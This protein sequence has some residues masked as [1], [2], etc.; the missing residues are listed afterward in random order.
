[1]HLVCNQKLLAQ[2]I[3]ICQKAISNKTTNDILKG[4]LLVAKDNALTL[5]GYDLEIAIETSLE[6][7]IYEEGS[8]VLDSRLFGDI[9]KK[10][11]DTFIEIK[12][13]Q[14]SVCV[15][16]ENSKFEIKSDNS[17]DFPRVPI[18]DSSKKCYISQSKLKNMI[19]QSVF[20]V[21]TDSSKPILTGE[22]LEIQENK[23]SLVAIDGYRLAV[24]SF[25]SNNTLENTK[26]IIPGKSLNDI[27]SLLS[28]SDDLVE[29]EFNE[30][31]V[32]FKFMGI[33][34]TTRVLEGD[35][36]EYKK[37]LP[38]EYN[39]KI[40]VKTKD[41][42]SSLERASL[43]SQMQKS[44]LIKLEIRENLLT[45]TSN[46]DKGNINE[47]IN[48]EFE[49]EFLDIAFNSRYLIEGIKN[50]EGS[51]IT[52]EFTTN[53]N[54]CVIKPIDNIDYTYLLLPVRISSS[55]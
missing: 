37:L 4:I 28:N 42:I 50:I 45:I 31:Y 20:A 19:K 22:L 21:S 17:N 3:N 54:P 10:L 18:L 41:L 49:G 35:F 34:V 16:Y 15:T 24:S 44:N 1:M 12:S 14:N 40:K 27:N 47:K 43:L 36:I 2:K 25:L 39:T 30:N 26:T 23:I 38:K 5:V 11:P 52:L 51:E 7:D 33:N 6:A 29:I 46:N 48:I 13:N 8:V 53:V 9:I 55:I 32:L